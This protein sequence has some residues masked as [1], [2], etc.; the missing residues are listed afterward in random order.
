[1]M[2]FFRYLVLP[3][4]VGLLPCLQAVP[5]EITYT[6][7][8]G[9]GF[10]DPAPRTPVGGNPGATLGEQRRIAFEFAARRWSDI[11]SGTIPIKVRASFAETGP[12]GD[13]PDAPYLATARPQG[14][15]ANPPGGGPLPQNNTNYPAALANQVV[16]EDTVNVGTTNDIVVECNSYYEA[17]GTNELDLRRWYYGL[18]AAPAVVWAGFANEPHFDFVVVALHEIGHG[19][20]F[21]SHLAEDGTYFFGNPTVWNR[22]MKLGDGTLLVSKS[23]AERA[24]ARTSNDL[25]I[26]SPNVVLYNEGNA[27]KLY[28]PTTFEQGSSMSHFDDATYSTEGSLNEL[29]TPVSTFGTQN[30]GPLV[31]NSLRDMGYSMAD[32]QAPVVAITSP[33]PG[34]SYK[35]TALAVTGTARDQSAAG[36]SA[37]AGLQRVKIAL[38]DSSAR[39]YSWSGGGF[40]T[41]TFNHAQHAKP[42]EVAGL[43]P[44]STGGKTWTA[45]LPAGLADGFYQIHVEAVDQLDQGS[46]YQTSTFTIDNA[47]PTTVIE[48]WANNDTVFNLE[49]FRASAPD[50]TTVTVKISRFDVLSGLVFYWS[51]TNWST[52]STALPAVANAGHWTLAVPL[53]SRAE[54]PVG[55]PVA[56][57]ATATDTA[58]NVTNAQVNLFR[59]A[60]DITLPVASVQSPPNGAVL[61]LP[62]LPS[63]QGLASDLET[64]ISSVTLTIT[65]FIPGGGIEFWSGSA[66][67]ASPTPLPV[68]HDSFNGSWTAPSG[69]NLPGGASLPNGGYSIQISATN[70]E[71]PAGTTGASSTF[72]VDYHPT[73]T[74]TGATLRDSNPNNDSNSWGVPENWSPYGVPDVNDYA[75]I[76]NGDAVTSTI[77]RSV[78]G[79][80]LLNGFLNFLNGPGPL[81]TITTSH[82]S[83]WAA[84]TLYGVWVNNGSLSINSPDNHWLWANSSLINTGT[85]THTSGGLIGRENSTI[86]NAAAGTWIT[87][88]SG[89][90]FGQYNGGNQFINQG[91]LR[92][93]AATDSEFNEWTFMI[94]G[95]VQKQG[96]ALVI[97]ANATL[98]AGTQFTG[99]G[100]FRIADGTITANGSL[101]NSGGAFH[102]S[103]GTIVSA[104]PVTLN[105]NHVWSGGAWQGNFTLSAGST[106]A[107]TGP[108]QLNPGT[109]L[110]NSGVVSWATPNPLVGRENTRINNLPGAVWRLESTGDAFANY[111]GGNVF[112]NEGKLE[113][114]SGDT[115]LLRHWD[116]LLP[117]ETKANAGTLFLAANWSWPAGALFSGA[118][119]IQMADGTITLGGEVFS[120]AASLRFTGGTMNGSPGAK[121]QGNWSWTGGSMGGSFENPVNRTLTFDGSSQLNPG[122]ALLNNGTVRW[123]GTSPLVGRENVAVTN[124]AGATWEIAVAGTPFAN[125]N[126]GNSFTN[127]GLFTRTAPA[128]DVHVNSWTYHQHGVFHAAAGDTRIG[129]TLNLM[130]GCSFTGAGNFLLLDQTW[131]KGAT[132]F[133]APVTT[134]GHFHGEAAGLAHGTL[135]WSAGIM[136][137]TV[138]VASG[139]TLRFVSPANRSLWYSSLI[140]CSGE[141]VWEDGGVEGRENATL[142]IRNGGTFRVQ[143]AGTFY[144]YNYNNHVV[145]DDGGSFEKTSTGNSYIHWAFDN[146]GSAAV[147]AGLLSLHGGGTGDGTFA[148]NTGGVL[149]FADGPHVLEGGATTT[150]NVEITGGSVLASGSAGGRMDVKGGTLGSSGTGVFSFAAASTCTGGVL[151]GQLRVPAGASL[152]TT[153]PDVKWVWISSTLEVSGLLEWQGGHPIMGRENSTIDVKPGGT[154]RAIADGDLFGNYNGGNRLLVA[155]TF[156]KSGGSGATTVDEWSVEGAGTIRPLTGRF[157]FNTVATFNGGTNYEGSGR[158]R[159][160]A[161]NLIARGTATIATGAT[162]EFSGATISGHA[163]GTAAFQGGAI[164]WSAGAVTGVITLN[165]ATQTTGAAEK[166][167][168]IGSELRNAGTMTVGGTGWLLGR[169]NSRLVNLPAG[170]MT[171]TGTSSF[172]N[173]NEGNRLV[174]EGLLR[175]GGS[176]GRHVMHWTFQQA[177]TGTLAIEVGGSNAAT[178]DFDVLQVHRPAQLAGTLSVTKVNGYLPAEDTTLSF[179]TGAPVTGTF[180][181]VNAPGFSVEYSGSSATL[182][183]S[184]AGLNFA[185]WAEDHELEGPDALPEADP[186][187]DG[188][189][190]FL[191]YAFNSDPHVPGAS[192]V[193]SGL[194]ENAGDTWIVVRY[195]RWQDRIDAGVLYQPEASPDLGGWD[196]VGVLDES[197]PD[198]LL[199]PGSEARRCRIP[200]SGSDRFLRLEVE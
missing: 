104:D 44:I 77:S 98:P 110:N 57:V 3:A 85:V 199:V 35:S 191:E 12:S 198:A 117:G 154:F 95:E 49:G 193:T 112:N 134:S 127:H 33:V 96:A 161:G 116:Y 41:T 124:A 187:R 40:T 5:I 162:V 61:N 155:G 51:G 184:A 200:V 47:A 6:D 22:M 42:V 26:G 83:E 135:R 1:M 71:S 17:N 93:T 179:L 23:Q 145:I 147:N 103:G 164:D 37:A 31:L 69:W 196:S 132:T 34:K 62:S 68:I 81:G 174:N 136:E 186:D 114:A 126:G 142:R 28:A 178:P 171:C 185:D 108:T 58:S 131:L 195:R 92:H 119:T 52:T 159:F 59:S 65:R 15:L 109:I 48:P 120:T 11:I 74:W 151:Y 183:A 18:D 88:A 79:F 63:L 190:N 146:D 139:A 169:E 89:D 45:S 122:A 87:A 143:S 13:P 99:P 66:W 133:S 67:S 4:L 20:G 192:P 168:W 75:V 148:G 172:G 113:K 153:G 160:N 90:I 16:N 72:T 111:N 36:T 56:V 121:I 29:M 39:W 140:D 141:V 175:I 14:Y 138:K 54:L 118:G 194:M 30:L 25:F 149:R 123:Q 21:V 177:A 86:T 152:A 130:T 163:D 70:R 180:A 91:I 173:Y 55:Q 129:S 60:P 97:R 106:L 53:P 157:D 115:T 125:Y 128:G 166:W 8:A 78:H 156:E 158:T 137:G 64:G 50:A 107:I 27:A 182:R 101:T 24:A 165:S 167:I 32:Q 105:G 46:G 43:S 76:A 84:G 144:N 38:S 82:S 100:G 19:L 189:V 2:K 197:D 181:T 7:P 102:H 176:V 170:T 73:Y 150:G 188:L 80:K 94:G 9:T 10:F